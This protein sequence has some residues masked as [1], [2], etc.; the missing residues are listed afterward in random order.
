MTSPGSSAS[1]LH[2][3]GRAAQLGALGSLA[4][5]WLFLPLISVEPSLVP[6]LGVF[7]F[8][9]VQWWSLKVRTA[10]QLPPV[11]VL[12]ALLNAAGVLGYQYYRTIQSEAQVSFHPP[13]SPAVY[14]TAVEIF[15]VASLSLWGG[16]MLVGGRPRERIRTG[17][18]AAAVLG[19]MNARAVWLIAVVPLALAVIGYG[20]RDLVE[21]SGYLAHSGPNICLSAASL[22]LPAGAA[23]VSFA[24]FGPSRTTIERLGLSVLLGV[25]SF[26]LFCMGTRQIAV[27]P[28]LLLVS[29]RANPTRHDLPRRLSLRI[30]L[31]TVV[32]TILLIALPLNIRGSASSAGA[33][34]F[35]AYVAEH[36]AMAATPRIA[37]IAGNILVAVP[38][39]STVQET[40]SGALPLHYFLTSINPLPGAFTDWASVYPEL[41]LNRA[42]PFSALGELAAYGW[43]ILVSYLLAVGFLLSFAQRINSSLPPAARTMVSVA[44]GAMTVLLGLD[45]LQYNLR[46]GTRL[47]WYVIALTLLAHVVHRMNAGSTRPGPRT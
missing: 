35:L 5:L 39:S 25:Y 8:T 47:V 29:W 16:G 40:A 20:P 13:D 18:P 28:S 24:L 4:V 42:T 7:G 22:F 9:A 43:P 1:G 21:R 26:T 30:L 44:T 41:G 12:L 34:P 19:T 23:V 14:N 37:A 2:D 32:A 33:A 11:A 46:S 31:P 15:L 27:L 10:E 17:R 6:V 38:L 36:P 45:L 3:G